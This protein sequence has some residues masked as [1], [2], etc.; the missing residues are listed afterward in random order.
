[1]ITLNMENNNNEIFN[2]IYK[3]PLADIEFRE[4]A[5]EVKSY[6]VLLQGVVLASTSIMQGH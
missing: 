1:M 2:F 5:L 4:K 3:Q 6:V